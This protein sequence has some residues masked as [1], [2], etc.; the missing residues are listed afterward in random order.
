M[1]GM[2]IDKGLVVKPTFYI[3][4]TEKGRQSLEKIG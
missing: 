4:I 2:L 3:L 1:L